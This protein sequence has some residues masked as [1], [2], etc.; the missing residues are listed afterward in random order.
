M[1]VL[2]DLRKASLV[3]ISSRQI[4]EAINSIMPYAEKRA[5]GKTAFLISNDP[6]YGISRMI[7][8][9]IDVKNIPFKVE[10]FKT[11]DEAVK[12]IDEE[13]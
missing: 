5:G 10:I 12:W 3:G 9:L 8:T 11:I 2:W 1:N 6:D 7:Q 4:N 13:E